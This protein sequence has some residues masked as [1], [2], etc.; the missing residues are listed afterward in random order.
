[1]PAAYCKHRALVLA[2]YDFNKSLTV[3]WT[4]CTAQAKR[5]CESISLERQN[6]KRGKTS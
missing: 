5:C 2:Q 4:F 3:L 6:R 1:M